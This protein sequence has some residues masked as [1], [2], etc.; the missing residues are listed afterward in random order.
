MPGCWFM[1]RRKLRVHHLLCVP[2]FVGEGYS[3]EFSRNMA[4]QIRY[5][6]QAGEELLE[7]TDEPDI[8]CAGCP[9]LTADRQCS[10]QNNLIADKDRLVARQLDIR[11]GE[12]YTYDELCQIARNKITAEFFDACCKQCEWYQKGLCSYQMWAISI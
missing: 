8:I 10:C 9:N 6:K 5:L 7:L 4:E 11:I 12:G 2:L 3:G 1:S